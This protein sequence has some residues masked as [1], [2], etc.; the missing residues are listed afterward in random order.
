MYGPSIV[1]EL[2]SEVSDSILLI[3]EE[4][5][6]SAHERLEHLGS[7]HCAQGNREEVLE[8]RRRREEEGDEEEGGGKVGEEG[9][10]RREIGRRI[11][12][13]GERGKGV[14]EEEQK[15]GEGRIERLSLH[16]ERRILHRVQ[17][18][19]VISLTALKT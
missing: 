12:G 18:A 13:D 19:L 9:R 14:R 7:K 17:M 2:S 1:R 11:G 16:E 5:D 4:G 15:D 3:I 10:E 8:K 6:V